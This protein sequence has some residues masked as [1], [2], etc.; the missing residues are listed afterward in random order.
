MTRINY[1]VATL[2]S[3]VHGTPRPSVL[4]IG[5]HLDIL[6]EKKMDEK[7]IKEKLEKVMRQNKQI[8]GFV[9]ISSVTREGVEQLKESIIQI[10]VNK[11]LVNKIVPKFYNDIDSYVRKAQENN[12][13]EFVSWNQFKT[14]IGK[15]L[16]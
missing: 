10:A 1:W 9:F 11:K 2:D 14:L 5:S 4:L 16:S 13:K 7:P 15:N 3:V 12:S 6:K 8:L